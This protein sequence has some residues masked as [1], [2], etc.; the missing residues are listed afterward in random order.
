VLV[1]CVSVAR[2]W[3]WG[4]QGHRAIAEAARNLELTPRARAAISTL[5]GNDDMAAVAV[6]LDEVRQ[7]AQGRGPLAHDAEAA[8]FNAQHPGNADWHFVNLPLSATTFSTDPAFAGAENVAVMINRCIRVLE[9]PA[10]TPTSMTRPQALRTLIHL[11][12]DVHQP[13]HVAS[14]YYEFGPDD[15]AILVTDPMKAKGR[16]GDRGGNLLHW[17]TGKSEELHA[18][19]DVVLVERITGGTD[20][21]ALAAKLEAGARGKSWSGTGDHRRDWARQWTMDALPAAALAY[22]DL[23]FGRA[24]FST[25]AALLAIDVQQRPDRATYLAT[26]AAI[27]ERQLTKAAGRLAALLDRIAWK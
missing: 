4:E 18:D 16:P 7:A 2:A 26:H 13:L 14:G 27:A 11:V 19:W 21:R 22:G 17:G 23:A 12:G 8:R 6:W 25:H 24:G 1:L 15:Q 5:L 3:G 20:Y 10:G 9:T